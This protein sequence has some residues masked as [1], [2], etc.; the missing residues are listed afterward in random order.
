MAMTTTR[1]RLCGLAVAL[2]CSQILTAQNGPEPI[3]QSFFGPS[4]IADK[5]GAYAGE[6]LQYYKDSPTLG[7]TLVPGAHTFVRPLGSTQSGLSVFGV[8]LS[9]DGVAMDWYAFVGEEGGRWKLHAVRS[10]ARTGIPWMLRQHL[11]V[12]S[13]RTP[14]EEWQLQ[15]LNLM[16]RSDAGLKEYVA[17]HLK[18]L[19]E[20]ATLAT[21]GKDNDATK[22]A[23]ALFVQSVNKTQDGRVELTIGGILDDSVGITFVPKGVAPPM[24]S[25]EN[26]I[27]VER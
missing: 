23:K 27:Y 6:M 26:Y 20:V 7:E 11:A 24:M 5:T 3:I 13:W 14:D 22:A 21:S 12:R 16:F 10:L 25:P 19:D 17:L 4:G 18:Q 1:C 15:N 9:V 8:L 2:M